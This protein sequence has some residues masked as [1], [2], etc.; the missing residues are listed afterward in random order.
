MLLALLAVGPCVAQPTEKGPASTRATADTSAATSSTASPSSVP[1]ALSPNSVGVWVGGSFASG[2]PIGNVPQ[3]R[4]GMIGLRYRHRLVPASSTAKTGLTLTYTVDVFPLLALSIP[5]NTV[6]FP[7]EGGELGGPSES[8]LQKWG[9]D[10]YGFGTSPA[11]LRLSAPVTDRVKPFISG[12]TGLLYFV[13][14]L[15]NEWGRHLNFMFDVGAGME[16]VLTSDLHL[17]LGYHYHHLSNG[18]RGRINPGIDAHLLHLGVAL[19]R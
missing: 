17:S 5:P 2:G 4:V 8:A 18:F 14:S 12:S 13:R 10:T 16:V 19:S 9:L 3:S 15:P 1:G 11:G 6:S 7:P